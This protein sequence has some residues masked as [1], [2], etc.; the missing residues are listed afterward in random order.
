LATQTPRL[1]N[2]DG[3]TNFVRVGLEPR[4][5]SDLHHYLM[6]SSWTRLFLLIFAVY[7][8]TNGLFAMLYFMDGG[9]ENAKTF[10]DHFFFSVHT[11]MT[12][13]YGTMA[14][15]SLTSNL[16]VAAQALFGL[17][18]TAT[19]TGLFFSKFSRPTARVLFSKVAVITQFDGAPALMFRMANE[20]T[21]QI[22]E[23]ELTVA[24]A[25][26]ESTKE[27]DRMRR[28]YALELHRSK[29][30]IF[31]LSWTAIHSIDEKSKL[32]NET[33]ESFNDKRLEIIVSFVGIDEISSQTV[34]ARHSYTASEIIWNARFAD[35]MVQHEGGHPM[36]DYRKFHDVVPS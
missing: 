4:L 18:Y 20:R 19:T 7:I 5:Y 35:I 10:G 23:A 21:N 28:F 1:L 15:K 30:A 8:I 25:R 34:H 33:A 36:I 16:L 3:S 27:G 17:L 22:V 6:R 9:V 13:G 29:S 14:P 24:V 12:I 2:R 31:A 11:M 32:F 26:F